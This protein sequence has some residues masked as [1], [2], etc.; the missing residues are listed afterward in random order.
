LASVFLSVSTF[1][2]AQTGVP[3]APKHAITDQYHGVG[4]TDDYR[5]LEDWSN[6]E[7]RAW[8]DSENAHTR[9]YL[10]A[11]PGRERLRD[12][13]KTILSTPSAHFNNLR[14]SGGVLFALRFQ[15]PKEQPFLVT[16]RSVNEPDS[17]RVILDPAQLDPS[18]HK[19]SLSMFHHL[20]E[21]TLL[22][23]SR[24]AEANQV[25]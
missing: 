19:L 7:T 25:I 18:G 10:D 22:F 9:S 5:W 1:V 15:P 3:P 21:N 6:P 2:C 20:T 8:S 13:I 14:R 23:R 11:L 12:Q 4:V 24:K 17:A 16:L